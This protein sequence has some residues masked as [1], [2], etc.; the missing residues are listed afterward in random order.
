MI[1]L[2]GVSKTYKSK[3]SNN[4][5][6]L[7]NIN[8]KLDDKG[9]TFILGKSGSGKSTL[10]NILGGLDK[11]D[12]GDMLILGKSTKEFTVAD[13]DSYRNT[14]VG[15]I[16]QEF[17]ILEDYDVYENIILAL[18]LQQKKINENEI[19][20]L[21][22]KLEL[23]ELKKRKV[24]E[25]SGGQKQ[26]VAIAR[27]LIK[28]PKIIL[29][30]EP[31]GNLDS[32]TG[33]Q[34]MDLLKNISKNKLVVIVSHDEESAKKYADRIIQV[35]D[36]EIVNDTN[37]K[38]YSNNDYKYQ[39]I[40]SK[41]PFKDSIRLGAGSL[42]HKKIKLFFTI[43]LT[44]ITLGF[45]SASDTLYN[46]DVNKDHANII[47]KNNEE[48]IE[49]K[50]VYIDE[51]ENSVPVEISDNN[52]KK[53]NS[54]INK[55]TYPVYKIYDSYDFFSM[56]MLENFNSG[57][58]IPN[59]ELE[60]IPTNNI[61]DIIKENII[62]R[63]PSSGNEI[64]ISNYLAN[65]IIDKGVTVYEDIIQ[66]EYIT[67]NIF[68]P[69]SYDELLNSNYTFYMGE[70]RKVKIVGIIDYDLSN[71]DESKTYNI[72]NKIF[73]DEDFISNI[74]NEKVETLNN[75]YN[76]SF[77]GNSIK[78]YED[79]I[80]TNINPATI[81]K[82]IEYYDGNTWKKT[83]LLDNNSIVI[84]FNGLNGIENYYDE[85]SSYTQNHFYEDYNE[86]EKKFFANYINRLN[87]IGST[88]NMKVYKDYSME[89]IIKEYKDIKIVGV[90]KPTYDDYGYSSYLSNDITE[91]YI[92][93]P[94]QQVSVLIPIDNNTNI[95]KILK[96]YPYDSNLIV[97]STYSDAIYGDAYYIKG[98]NK[99][100]LYASL[101]FLIFAIFLISNFMINSIQYRKKEIGVLR[102]LGARSVDIVKIFLLEGIIIA[103][104]SGTIASILLVIISNLC[105]NLFINELGTIIAPFLVGFRQF[106]VIYLLV[107]IVTLIAS[108]IPMI[109]ISK[110]KPIDAIL[111]K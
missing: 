89:N 28:K 106:V 24:N 63:N 59:I 19:N 54:S 11:Y 94:I 27:A 107:F 49:I 104:I 110:M 14:Y 23:T 75:F 101:V 71:F 13:F 77:S 79:G 72:Y 48:F 103:I 50:E 40:K 73:V 33:S 56:M 41:L 16:F 109:R 98:L 61:N 46:Y 1:E 9:M 57:T 4:T 18:Q 5:K 67:N 12:S 51:Y 35:V 37:D 92:A 6:A 29:A 76:Y 2:K 95:N 36:G 3:K 83:G 85:L 39:T 97:K 52:I 87:V 108:I 80:S 70:N 74:N 91:D 102:A 30:D 8:L 105:N 21:L 111:N 45:F 65:F 42:R 66:D 17:N 60:F 47:S 69:D 32:K 34:V 44:I 38:T 43:L 25:L 15:F 81:I 100:F 99:L 88:V 90:Y 84:N 68:K 22:D 53:V 55:T 7:N 86:L 78:V 20:E 62:G 58:Q 96:D 10:L 26:R 93:K 82:E 64:V 31:T